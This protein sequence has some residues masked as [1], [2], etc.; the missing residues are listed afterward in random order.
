M[1]R[2]TTIASFGY[3]GSNLL[4]AYSI[5]SPD[6]TFLRGSIPAGLPNSALFDVGGTNRYFYSQ[7][8]RSLG[9]RNTSTLLGVHRQCPHDD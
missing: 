7:E 3:G 4:P 9:N 5:A 2:G 1:F 8:Y 6:L